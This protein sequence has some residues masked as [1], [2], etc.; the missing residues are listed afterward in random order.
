M[1]GYDGAWISPKAIKDGKNPPAS[2]RII[3]PTSRH[4]YVARD[5]RQDADKKFKAMNEG[6]AEIFNI[7]AL[8][9]D[10]PIFITEG[11]IDAI[12]IIEAGG[13]ALALGST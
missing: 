7:K 1:L 6:A 11:A 9:E 10:A 3:I 13:Q 4:S 8:Q 5:T 2:P 12:S